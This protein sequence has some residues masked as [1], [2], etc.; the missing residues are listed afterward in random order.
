MI[1]IALGSPKPPRAPQPH[2]PTRTPTELLALGVAVSTPVSAEAWVSYMVNVSPE[3]LHR[4]THISTSS[5]H[6]AFA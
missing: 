2:V 4:H 6:H 5:R 1:S 3:I